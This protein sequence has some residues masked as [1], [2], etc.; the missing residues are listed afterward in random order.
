[1]FF[2]LKTLHKF[3]IM[4]SSKTAPMIWFILL[5]QSCTPSAQSGVLILQAAEKGGAAARLAKFLFSIYATSMIPLVLLS[6]I[7]LDKF[8]MTSPDV[9]V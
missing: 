6:T 9:L 1:M 4:E 3:G 8:K 5:L 7:L 2:M